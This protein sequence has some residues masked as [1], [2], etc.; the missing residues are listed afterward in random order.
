MHFLRRLLFG[1]TLLVLPTVGSLFFRRFY[2]VLPWFSAMSWGAMTTMYSMSLWLVSRRSLTS[3]KAGLFRC[4]FFL[5]LMF[6][7]LL[8]KSAI[9]EQP[10]TENSFLQH[11]RTPALHMTWLLSSCCILLP[12]HWFLRFDL[13]D[14]TQPELE[15]PKPSIFDIAKW[16]SL[17]AFVLAIEQQLSYPDQNRAVRTLLVKWPSVLVGIFAASITYFAIVNHVNWRRTTLRVTIAVIVFMSGQR[18]VTELASPFLPDYSFN[19]HISR[20]SISRFLAYTSGIVL[21]AAS[22]A[23]LSRHT[24]LSFNVTPKRPWQQNKVMNASRI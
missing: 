19:G 21:I 22:A 17:F 5:L 15:L 2:E 4:S 7:G 9:M 3:T 13:K 18:L 1:L 24:G 16:M 10:R 23:L 12:V 20:A 8:A 11:L 6:L 14:A